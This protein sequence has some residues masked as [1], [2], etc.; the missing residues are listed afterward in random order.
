MV[1]CGLAGAAVQHV[2]RHH[3]ARLAWLLRVDDLGT[4]DILT[5][6]VLVI[7]M[8]WLIGLTKRMSV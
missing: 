5:T 3:G 2:G 6:L 8:D 4:D 1:V 7:V